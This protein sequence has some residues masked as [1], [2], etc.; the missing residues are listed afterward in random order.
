[1]YMITRPKFEGVEF[2]ILEKGGS[3]GAKSDMI[4]FGFVDPLRIEKTH[5]Y[6]LCYN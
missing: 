1:M 4:P 2:R 5:V 3:Q 6:H